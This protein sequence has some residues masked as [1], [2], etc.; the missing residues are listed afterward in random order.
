MK[1]SK[2]LLILMPVLGLM[3]MLGTATAS[4]TT[5]STDTNPAYVTGLNTSATQLVFGEYNSVSC[6]EDTFSAKLEGFSAAHLATGENLSGCTGSSKSVSTNGCSVEFNV[7]SYTGYGSST[8]TLDIGPKGCGPIVMENKFGSC[9]V[10]I[11]SQTNIAGVTYGTKGS[12]SSRYLAVSVNSSTLTYVQDPKHEQLCADGT[13]TN[14]KLAAQVNLKATT[15]A[16][17]PAPL[18]VDQGAH[19]PIFEAVSY[20]S[21]FSGSQDSSSQLTIEAGKITCSTGK[22]SGKVTAAT[23]TL[24][25]KPEYSGCS[26][27]FLG[28]TYSATVKPNGCSYQATV[29][30]AG[31]P[32]EGLVNLACE[33]AG[34]AIEVS[35]ER[36]SE[37]CLV[38]IAPQA[39][40]SKITYTTGEGGVSG[41]V[42]A[43]SLTY[44]QVGVLCPGNQFSSS[45]VFSNGQATAS[46]SLS[47][48]YLTG[49]KQ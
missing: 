36:P 47:A 16:G 12:G 20:P 39:A 24:L 6:S 35:I 10:E 30:N 29:V 2:S 31:P 22:L 23:T 15:G 18:Y 27:V 5:F 1:R 11:P 42:S 28:A 38:K 41:S 49:S 40:G 4:A 17:V 19:Q 13:F 34:E 21:N 14:G 3:M 7:G 44:T 32:Y 45:R 48:L 37:P 43:S 46:G 26:V 8:G 33:K 9:T 25:V